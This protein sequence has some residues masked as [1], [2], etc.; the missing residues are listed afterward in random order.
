ME[1]V[2]LAEILN[3][4]S[5]PVWVYDLDRA[6]IL[7]ANRV[8]LD[9]WNADG[10]EGLA[11]RNMAPSS[12]THL[13]RLANYRIQFAKGEEVIDVWTLYPRDTPVT[14]RCRF[15]GMTWQ[16]NAAMGVEILSRIDGLP[17]AS[18]DGSAEPADPDAGGEASWSTLLRGVELGRG[19]PLA[20][21]LVLA[22][23]TVVAQNV[24]ADRVFGRNSGTGTQGGAWTFFDRFVDGASAVVLLDDVLKRGDVE[25]RVAA[26]NTRSGTT[27]SE[28]GGR[29]SRDPVTGAPAVLVYAMDVTERL[30][31][32]DALRESEAEQQRLTADLKE[33]RDVAE[34]A[35]AAKS[36]FL[37]MM[38][39]EIRTPM[40]GILGL[41]EQMLDTELSD[42]QRQALGSIK[43]S[44]EALLAVINDI[45][46][47]SRME[48]GRLTLEVV[49]FNLV[50]ACVAVLDLLRPSAEE[51]ALVLDHI[52]DPA[53][54]R[55][56]L[57]DPGRLR[58]VLLNI[59][60]NAIKFTDEGSV[61]LLVTRGDLP[62]EVVFVVRDTGAGIASEAL[63]RLFERFTQ[64]DVSIVR[65]FGGSGL[66]LTISRRLVSMMGGT[67][68][69]ESTLG[70]G[71]VFTIRVRLPE[72]EE[73][74]VLL[75]AIQESRKLLPPRLPNG[76]PI[77][78]L[79]AEDNAINQ[80]VLKGFLEPHGVYVDVAGNGVE[81][82]TMAETKLYDIILMDMR[83]PEMDGVT[84]TEHIR[85]GK[86]K[87]RSA[88]IVAVTA[89]AYAEDQ[90]RCLS[91]G[92]NAFLSK[93]LRREA[94]FQ[95]MHGL[96]AG[97]ETP[98]GN[99]EVS[100]EIDLEKGRLMIAVDEAHLQELEEDLGIDVMAAMAHQFSEAAEGR[101]SV[102]SD[103]LAQGKVAE[104]GREA[105]SLKGVSATLGLSA[106]R[107]LATELDATCKEGNLDAARVLAESLAP[108][109]TETLAYLSDRYRTV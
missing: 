11:R 16:G 6:R 74:Q 62:D 93:P 53:P 40:N 59:L 36:D 104:A 12:P 77:H 14:L 70:E 107:D 41:S 84:A 63:P 81:A 89:N 73:S 25:P 37:A 42:S 99:A 49:P 98:S 55:M 65:R 27:F 105:H 79:V 72:V 4:L 24:A 69:A 22:D 86:G 83:M 64:A 102:L 28:V 13:E 43:G 82:W 20:V 66:G 95:V 21:S 97:E 76:R 71:S 19:T 8:A 9:L 39:H 18:L 103:A 51:K 47:F 29:R 3:G 2:L 56:V 75:H 87:S 17:L 100:K 32:E 38:S 68:T 45:L 30:I 10:L 34:R 31:R 46:D 78:L 88:P 58:Q 48:A 15:W 80:Q 67:V 108:T 44:S 90:E 92:M 94:L 7:W 60:G 85:S 54:R 52:F 35:N 57:G 101:L 61:N 109:M 26:M 23:G 50:E 33:A 106:V 1:I 91:A 96:L 5:T